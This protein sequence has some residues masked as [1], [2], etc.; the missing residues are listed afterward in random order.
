MKLL[1]I[2]DFVRR[3]TVGTVALLTFTACGTAMAAGFVATASL[4]S[5][6][7][8]FT[9]TVLSSGSV[10][11]S[12]GQSASTIV[13]GAEL[14]DPV[15]KSWGSGGLNYFG[16]Y[17]HTA[18]LLQS[19]MVL[20]CGGDTS[21][22][23]TPACE[24]YNPTINAWGLSKSMFGT[25]Y[26]HTASLLPSGKVLVA[27]GANPFQIAT[28]EVYDPSSNT[29][30][31]VP[32]MS[33]ARTAHT[34]TVLASGKVLVVGGAGGGAYQ[35]STEL[36]DPASATWSPGGNLAEGRAG[37]M[38][39]LLMNGQVL[40]AG[41]NNSS[42]A[43]A[44]VELYDPTTNT[45]T[46]AAPMSVAR[47]SGAATLLASGQVLVAGGESVVNTTYLASAEIFDPGSGTWKSA[48]A[49]NTARARQRAVSIG[50]G[51]PLFVG[52]VNNSAI[53]GSA[54]LYD[55]STTTAITSI[56]PSATVVGEAYTLNVSVSAPSGIATGSVLI[57]DGA[58]STCLATL[59]GGNG[60]CSLTSTI[61]GTHSVVATFA[62]SAGFDA[63]TSAA[64]A[65]AVDRAGTS[66][67]IQTHT[68]EPS[69]PTQAVSV[70]VSF[71]VDS[72]GAGT[73][74]GTVTIDDG[75]ES[76]TIDVGNDGCS[77]SVSMRGSQTITASY[78]GDANFASSQAQVAH[79]VNQLPVAGV[80]HYATPAARPLT[81]DAASG[82][83][84]GAS[85][86]DDDSLS[87]ASAGS[88]SANGIGGSVEL[89]ADGSF[90]YT[91]PARASGTAWFDYVISDGLENVNATA[92]ITVSPA[93]DL[94]I[95]IDNNATFLSGG[96]PI[97]YTVAVTNAGP[98]DVTGA[99]VAVALSANL[100]DV[101]WE[102][103]GDAGTVCATSGTGALQDNVTLPVG[104]HITYVLSAA[105]AV[106]PEQSATATATITAPSSVPD[107]VTLNNSASD[108]DAVG[109]FADGFDR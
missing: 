78:A 17:G 14:Y 101:F 104:T 48:G 81:I 75:V 52:G 77:L 54:E 26:Y 16:R 25:R 19:G 2:R 83:L 92:T 6:R 93:A 70:T 10:L 58:G 15:S 71:T 97:S 88:F 50:A 67:T 107:P 53:L 99:L 59:S 55:P 4:T 34:A 87:I 96:S 44:S 40:I 39:I 5:P 91:P 43:L 8:D 22:G 23:L 79:R 94:S 61:A 63:S 18:T 84:S 90:I 42:G 108:A 29:W 20:V 82:V 27:G 80:A 37:H 60:S 36:Y 72:P 86:P 31:G 106:D 66:L 95:S 56:V 9:A 12:G 57:D 47:A 41:G 13:R 68:P 65:H 21:G 64:Q 30:M 69:T 24:L 33:T 103:S 11:V 7:D 76:C 105:V 38:A 45:W 62:G 98:S 28:A 100:G 46:S 73:P 109:I 49:M 102:C 35:A 85:D 3:M 51:I 74:T 1:L 89:R 32:S